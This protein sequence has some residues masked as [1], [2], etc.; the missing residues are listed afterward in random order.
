M[1]YPNE[2]IWLN[3]TALKKICLNRDD[4]SRTDAKYARIAP[5]LVATLSF[6]FL[7]SVTNIR[8]Y[9]QRVHGFSTLILSNDWT[10]QYD[11]TFRQI[12]AYLK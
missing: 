9:F 1:R 7:L 4:P 6:T 5:T 2:I 8:Y 10:I 12:T 11:N 3:S